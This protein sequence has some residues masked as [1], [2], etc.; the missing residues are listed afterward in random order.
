M[1]DRLGQ[2]LLRKIIEIVAAWLQMLRLKCNKFDFPLEETPL[3]ELWELTALPRHLTGFKGP[4]LLKKGRER[5]G[6][7]R[8]KRGWEGE[9]VDR[10]D[11]KGEGGKGRGRGR[12]DTDRRECSGK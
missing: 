5:K 6:R 10:N 4:I 3:K 7:G 8:D 12:K 9:G 11:W 1:R 2:L